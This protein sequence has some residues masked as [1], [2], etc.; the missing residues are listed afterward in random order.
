ML[1][2]GIIFYRSQNYQILAKNHGLFTCIIIVHVLILFY[3]IPLRAHTSFPQV[4]CY[5]R[6]SSLMEG[7]ELQEALEI[8]EST[9]LKYFTKEMVAEF[10]ALKGSFLAQIGRYIYMC[11][12]GGYHFE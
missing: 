3:Q 11:V 12:Y 5:L 8:I 6:M 7:T 1:L 2:P 9:N 10:M 4:K